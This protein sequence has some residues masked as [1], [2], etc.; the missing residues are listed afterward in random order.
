MSSIF[1]WQD[2]TIL[3]KRRPK[4]LTTVNA[5]LKGAGTIYWD[6]HVQMAAP[7]ADHPST[8]KWLLYTGQGDCR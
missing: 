3:Q 4:Y 8:T 6:L 2:K 1:G 7:H 5:T